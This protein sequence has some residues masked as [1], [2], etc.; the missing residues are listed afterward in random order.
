LPP[1]KVEIIPILRSGQ[2]EGR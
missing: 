2:R 1:L